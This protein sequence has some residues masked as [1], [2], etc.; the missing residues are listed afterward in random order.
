VRRLEPPS[1]A[2]REH[3]PELAV[4]YVLDASLE[5]ARQGVAAAQATLRA[6]AQPGDEHSPRLCLG[7]V[8][9]AVAQ[10][11]HSALRAYREATE[12]ERAQRDAELD[13]IPY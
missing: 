13:P 7:A 6:A 2:E 10:A 1:P 5:A 4:L 8:L 3:A 12:D 9:L 11:L